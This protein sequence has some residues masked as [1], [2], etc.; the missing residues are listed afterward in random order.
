MSTSKNILNAF[1][2]SPTG[3]LAA[4]AVLI[5]ILVAIIA[6]A[7]WGRQ[8]TVID[9]MGAGQGP[10]AQHIFGT[11]MLGRDILA[12]TL[13][14]TRLSLVLAVSAAAIAAALGFPLGGLVALLGPRMRA[15]GSRIIDALLAFPMII[16]VI[17]IT[18]IVGAGPRGAVIAVAIAW[19]PYWARIASTLAASIA[20]REYM[21]NARVIGVSGGRLLLRY[22]LPNFAETL[23]ITVITALASILIAISSLSF[24]G[25]GVQP[26][27]YDWGRM[28]IEG[29]KSIYITPV[30]AL[31]PA[32]AIAITGLSLGFLS[33]AV[34]RV[35]NPVLW[36]SSENHKS[37]EGKPSAGAVTVAST[38]AAAPVAAAPVGALP[39]VQAGN[40]KRPLLHVEGLSVLFSSPR[41]PI[42]PVDGSTFDIAPSEVV[43]IVGESGSG[44]SMTALAIAQ[45]VPYPGK[46]LAR[47]LQLKGE[48]LLKIPSKRL[49]TLLGTEMAMVFQDPM[50]SLNPA[51]RIGLQL[52]EA[53]QV[54]RGLDSKTALHL[55]IDRMRD[56]QIP[57]AE[58]RLRQYPH[59]FSGGMRQ[60]A[61]IAMGLMN[62][63][64]LIICDEP[65]TALDVTIQAQIM[66]LLKELNREFGTAILLISH[67]I[68][69][70][71]EI[72][73]RVLVM[74]AGRII[75]DISI[76]KLLKEA[77][78]P[79]TRGLM[80]AV[81]DLV[82]DRTKP[83]A[84]I[85]GRPPDLDS[86]P[87]G[88]AFAP[89]CPLAAGRCQVE[90]PFLQQIAEGHAVACWTFS[91]HLGEAEG[92]P[93][94]RN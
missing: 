20:G 21:A 33:E 32:A 61:M 19:V 8:A 91:P 55:A 43:G 78:H 17:V 80:A 81:P 83:L 46:V 93:E 42:L 51:L 75:E 71:S 9:T 13:T 31:A 57:A 30:A 76:S 48:E 94:C 37:P 45:L 90:K 50:S 41:G 88:C 85:P 66:D 54:H 1:A 82:A 87:D 4:L 29:V 47:S 28:L 53:S 92:N 49:Q 58:A 35:M 15:F 73:S 86:L 18:A 5:L 14:A 6:P 59:E 27:A 34:A 84:T 68:G 56:V 44:K 79:Y 63:P 64:S 24:L 25:L 7:V 3:P 77:S 11:D 67:D 10:S 2:R 72:C 62:Q 65:T 40:G 26:P 16:I 22:V 39:T 89:R 70:I 52:T 12:R 38:V 23:L 69:V 74:Y 36:T 60:R